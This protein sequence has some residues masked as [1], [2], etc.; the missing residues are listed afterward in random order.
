[1]DDDLQSR[2]EAFCRAYAAG[3]SGAAAARA[4]GY[5]S[6]GAAKQAARLLK[7]GDVA[8]RVA[9]LRAEAAERRESTVEALLAKLEPVYTA[10]LNGQDYE[11]VLQVVE[12]QARIKGLVHGAAATRRRNREPMGPHHMTHE[13]WLELLD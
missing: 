8:D 9:E 12:L 5:E 10:C 13:E 3:A 11:G 1:M 7:R 6:S 2:Q 4:A